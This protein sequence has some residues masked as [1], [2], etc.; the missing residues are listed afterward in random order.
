VGTRH[1]IP[2]ALP[3]LRAAPPSG[4]AWSHEVKFDGYRVQL[5]KA[6]DAVS[7]LSKNGHV[8][9]SRFDT[10]ALAMKAFPATSIV[11]DGEIV[12]GDRRDAPDF[13]RLHRRTA[14][15]HELCV[16]AFDLLEHDGFDVRPLPLTQGRTKL[17]A[18]VRRYEHPGILFS[19]SFTDPIKLLAECEK[20]RLEGIVSKRMDRPYRSG[21]RSEWI[22][23]KCATWREAHRDRHEL[24]E[25]PK[26]SRR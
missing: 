25:R 12:A 14:P 2:P 5:H 10:I 8:F 16:W 7:I 9:T 19:E 17:E 1:F 6:G 15:P 21:D 26:R 18:L 22:K 23:V 3:T 20:R 24:F 4:D 11:I 13:M